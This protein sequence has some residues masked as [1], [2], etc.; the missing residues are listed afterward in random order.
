MQYDEA[1]QDTKPS[2]DEECASISIE[3]GEDVANDD[4]EDPF[5]EDFT[6]KRAAKGA[7]RSQRQEKEFFAKRV[8]MLA[9][10]VKKR[11]EASKT[12]ETDVPLNNYSV[13]QI[14]VVREKLV[15]RGFGVK[16]IESKKM[17]NPQQVRPTRWRVTWK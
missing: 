10:A 3:D 12:N 15:L 2:T 16:V 9:H 6:A 13:D 14:D 7:L 11:V 4:N 5:P 8:R 17:V 1:Q